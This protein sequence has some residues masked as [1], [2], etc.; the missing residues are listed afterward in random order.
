M[1]RSILDASR[2][3]LREPGD[4]GLGPMK[5]EWSVKSAGEMGAGKQVR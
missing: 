2:T 5:P 4:P 1:I 3:R